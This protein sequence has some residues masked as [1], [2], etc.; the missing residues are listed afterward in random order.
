MI[1]KRGGSYNEYKKLSRGKIFSSVKCECLF[2]VRGYLLIACD[3]SLKVDY[4]RHNHEMEDVLKGHKTARPLRQ[5]HTNLRKSYNRTSATI[6]HIYNACHKY[7]QSIRGT[8]TNMHHLLKSLVEN[9]YVYYCGKYPDSDDIRDIF[10]SHPNG[11]KLFSTFSMVL[12]LD[13]TYKTNTYHL[14]LL[15]FVG[16][17]FTELTFSVAFAY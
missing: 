12:V 16:V 1:W 5:I 11:T 2:S 7:R 15:E 3:W 10:W 14:L 8:R 6:K 9:E 17:T 13:S 4:G